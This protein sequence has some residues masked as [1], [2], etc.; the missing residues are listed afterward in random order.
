MTYTRYLL[1][2]LA[3][4]TG[5]QSYAGGLDI[6]FANFERQYKIENWPQL[7]GCEYEESFEGKVVGVILN[8]STSG[9]ESRWDGRCHVPIWHE[10]VAW[11]ASL[12][13]G[14]YVVAV[15]SV[16]RDGYD[17]SPEKNRVLQ[18]IGVLGDTPD[19]ERYLEG[20]LKRICT[21]SRPHHTDRECSSTQ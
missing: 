16:K 12:A 21:P 19:N 11:P 14:R 3:L 8:V 18:V 6:E 4:V 15:T 7:D 9:A 20:A 5:F 2:V 10:L 1:L 13:L 17:S